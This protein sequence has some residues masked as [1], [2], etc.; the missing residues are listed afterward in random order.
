[1]TIAFDSQWDTAI[2]STGGN[3]AITPVGTPRAVVA[4][5]VRLA[6][7]GD[8]ITNASY[9]G[10]PMAE[11]ANSP[12]AQSVGEQSSISAFFLGAGIPTG[13]QNFNF[14]GTGASTIL[15]YVYVYTADDDCEIVA[16][17]VINEA[18]TEEPRVTLALANR[19]CAVAQGVSSGKNF[20]FQMIALTDWTLDDGDQ[21]S[22]M[23]SAQY[24][25]DLISN[26]DVEC[27]WSQ[28]PGAEEASAICV[29]MSELA[30]AGGGTLP[31]LGVE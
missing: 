26:V 20:S 4:W 2:I 12:L 28:A 18:S 17:D 3:L 10:V 27:G 11:L 9:G 7:D 22:S 31:L 14:T 6:S 16:E 19:M 1:M 23:S 21:A 30:A 24:S 29:A 25:Y 5:L 13:L 8:L 15:V